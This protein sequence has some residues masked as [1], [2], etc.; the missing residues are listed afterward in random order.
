MRNCLYNLSP[1]K[2][3]SPKLSV[4]RIEFLL[5]FS[6][7]WFS[8]TAAMLKPIQSHYKTLFITAY[9]ISI[10]LIFLS[11]V[12]STL[13]FFQRTGKEY[14]CDEHSHVPPRFPFKEPLVAPTARNAV[15]P[16]RSL[17]LWKAIW[18]R[19]CSSQGSPRP[20][21]D[22]GRAPWGLACITA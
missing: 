10:L 19:R 22:W 15:S 1:G 11:F 2:F 13:N 9:P 8:I 12:L 3:F 7:L 6:Y 5:W 18:R 4:I 17:W 16:L 21:A 14:I 20:V